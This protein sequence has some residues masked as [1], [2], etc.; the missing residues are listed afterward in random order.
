M[1][2]FKAFLHQSGRGYIGS[3]KRSIASRFRGNDGYGGN[4]GLRESDVSRP[5]DVIPAQAGIHDGRR[6]PKPE[7][8]R[9][10]R[11]IDG[12]QRGRRRPSQHR[13]GA[14]SLPGPW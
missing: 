9:P 1:L 11:G 10:L 6:I 2:L 14:V 7:V 3:H 8:P 4:D 5:N 13:T 12:R